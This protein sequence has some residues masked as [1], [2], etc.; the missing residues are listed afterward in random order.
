M[1]RNIGIIIA[2]FVVAGA[3]PFLGFMVG[4]WIDQE[5]QSSIEWKIALSW[6]GLV[7]GLWQ[8]VRLIR[9]E[10]LKK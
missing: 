2:S 10:I 4:F 6:A 5:W 8:A 7:M 3:G 9:I 1:I